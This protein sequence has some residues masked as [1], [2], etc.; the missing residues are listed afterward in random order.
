VPL[1]S[2]A[3]SCDEHIVTPAPSTPTSE[4]GA[5]LVSSP[6]LSPLAFKLTG[7]GFKGVEALD[8]LDSQVVDSPKRAKSSIRSGPSTPRTVY[9]VSDSLRHLS[10]PT[11]L[12]ELQSLRAA[13]WELEAEARRPFR[14]TPA[15]I[16]SPV[17]HTPHTPHTPEASGSSSRPKRIRRKAVP[18]ISEDL[19]RRVLPFSTETPVMR[20]IIPDIVPRVSSEGSACADDEEDDAHDDDQLDVFLSCPS[21]PAMCPR[22]L[23]SR[24]GMY[25]NRLGTMSAI[26]VS[27]RHSSLRFAP[28]RAVPMPPVPETLERGDVGYASTSSLSDHLGTPTRVSSSSSH[29]GDA[30]AQALGKHGSPGGIYRSKNAF[31]SMLDLG[32]AK[33]PAQDGQKPAPGDEKKQRRGLAKLLKRR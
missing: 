6:E 4:V 27:T 30:P 8:A 18:V 11:T 20:S 16:N 12:E 7:L 9:E 24:H 5:Q 2:P 19:D 22:E 26:E 10:T 25:S 21:S 31:M 17:M 32:L 15:T 14:S 3:S 23:G 13:A 29:A 28:P 33:V 1:E